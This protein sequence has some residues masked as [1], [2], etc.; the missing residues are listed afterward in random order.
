MARVS[1]GL[2][3]G[4]AAEVFSLP[5]AETDSSSAGTQLDEG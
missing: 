2:V 3:S 4:E 1:K 5:L